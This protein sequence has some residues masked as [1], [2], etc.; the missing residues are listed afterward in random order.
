M[1]LPYPAK[2]RCGMV[3]RRPGATSVST[4][5]SSI[6]YVTNK[7]RDNGGNVMRRSLS[8]LATLGLWLTAAIVAVDPAFGSVP[9]PGPA[10]G[11][12]VPALALFGVGYWLIRRRRKA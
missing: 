11:V 12:G 8:G 6:T 9:V 3:W 2:A 4:L 7:W 10:I 5:L 1:E